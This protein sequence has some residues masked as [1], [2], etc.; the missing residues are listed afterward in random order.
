MIKD[1][2]RLAGAAQETCS[3][4]MLG[5]QRADFLRRVAFWSIRSS[6]LLR[7]FCVTGAALWMTWP[8]FFVAATVITLD[9]WKNHN[10]GYPFLF[11]GYPCSNFSAYPRIL[12]PSGK[13]L[14]TRKCLWQNSNGNKCCCARLFYEHH[15]G[16]LNVCN[17]F[18][19]SSAIVPQSFISMFY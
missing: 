5:G 1:A 13:D 10:S 19:T 2:F 15:Y 8:H 7:C 3:S 12:S 9:N 18:S 16:Q 6:G 14:Q 11:S 17:P 4:E